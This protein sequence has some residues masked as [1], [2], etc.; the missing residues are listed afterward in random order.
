MCR[1]RLG[2]HGLRRGAKTGSGDDAIGTSLSCWQPVP[3]RS[4][5]MKVLRMWGVLRASAGLRMEISRRASP[6]TGASETSCR[7][8]GPSNASSSLRSDSRKTRPATAELTTCDR[9]WNWPPL[10]SVFQSRQKARLRKH[11]TLRQLLAPNAYRTISGKC[12]AAD[13]VPGH[14]VWGINPCLQ[15]IY[16]EFALRAGLRPSVA[17]NPSLIEAVFPMAC[18][19]I[20]CSRQNREFPPG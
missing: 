4:D 1:L 10:R 11:L 6:R 17:T 12:L 2:S 7:P 16:R 13:T 14:R 18:E 8:T 15:G 5:M 9:G 20:P 19:R 3:K